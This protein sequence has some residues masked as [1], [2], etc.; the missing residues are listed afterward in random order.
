MK[1]FNGSFFRNLWRLALPYWF[2][3]EQ[4]RSAGG[5]LGL[6]VLLN[7]LTVYISYRVTE[8]Y[9]PFWEALQHYNSKG[10]F[11]QLWVFILLVTPLVIA[12]VYQTYF[13]QMLQIRW[14]RWLTTRYLDAWLDHGTH[15]QMQIQSDGTDNPDQRIAEDL[16]SFT[17]Q[18]LDLFV[19][20]FGS[21]TNVT[22]TGIRRRIG[23]GK[24]DFAGA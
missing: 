11:R 10:A 19:G 12:S 20:A 22:C 5:L 7:L 17:R 23:N 21:V 24:L 14:R 3:S 6:I 2:T 8:W 9:N 15:Y 1:Q 18:T 16:D 4:R 13:T